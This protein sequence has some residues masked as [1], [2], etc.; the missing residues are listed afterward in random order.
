MVEGL[1]SNGGS[2]LRLAVVYV[3]LERVNGW[4]VR[5]A[6][7]SLAVCC[8]EWLGFLLESDA[9]GSM[10]YCPGRPGPVVTNWRSRRAWE[11]LSISWSIKIRSPRIR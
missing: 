8:V 11:R 1:S 9:V 4:E 7:G 5:V 2:V 6:V 10:R 3:V